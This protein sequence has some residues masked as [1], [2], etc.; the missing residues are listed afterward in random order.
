MDNDKKKKAEIHCHIIG[1]FVPEEIAHKALTLQHR[2]ARKLVWR[3]GRH[4]EY[5]VPRQ[6]GIWAHRDFYGVGEYL[7]PGEID[8]DEK[9]RKIK[10]RMSLESYVITGRTDIAFSYE[11]NSYTGQITLWGRVDDTPQ[12]IRWIRK[13]FKL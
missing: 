4:D 11:I 3:N 12:V 8:D 10:L 7:K 9:I 5:N 6:E 1:L 2:H 13:A